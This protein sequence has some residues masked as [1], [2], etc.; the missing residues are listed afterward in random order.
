M[1]NET[2]GKYENGALI[3]DYRPSG[4]Q[5]NGQSSSVWYHGDIKEPQHLVNKD[6]VDSKKSWNKA[7]WTHGPG[8]M[9]HKY[10]DHSGPAL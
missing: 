9:F 2:D 8:S 5:T 3:K 7:P 6:Y 1:W 4:K 10:L